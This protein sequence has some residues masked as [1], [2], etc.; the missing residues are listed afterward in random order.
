MDDLLAAAGM[1]KADVDRLGEAMRQRDL[2]DAE[3]DL[4]SSYRASF[5]PALADVRGVLRDVGSLHV[6]ERQ[7]TLWATVAKLRRSTAR[8]SQVQDI[9]GCRVVVSD[10]HAQNVL[11]ERLITARPEWRLFDR[12]YRPSHEYR[13]VHV[14]AS[15]GRLPVEIQIRTELQHVWAELSEAWDRVYQGVKY[16][17]GPEKVL[18]MLALASS[19]VSEVESLETL[20]PEV[21]ASDREATHVSVRATLAR[22]F[23]TSSDITDRQ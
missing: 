11:T 4:F 1:R 13:A 22:L 10:T 20:P 8:L 6:T 19:V 9:A 15:S 14:V 12:R 7:K 18:D 16:G 2:D 5:L 17:S 21:L 3:V 23:P